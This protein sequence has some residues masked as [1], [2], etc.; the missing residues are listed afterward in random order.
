MEIFAELNGA[1]QLFCIIF[2]DINNYK[3]G[4]WHIFFLDPFSERLYHRTK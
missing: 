1:E 4:Y 3:L 2:W